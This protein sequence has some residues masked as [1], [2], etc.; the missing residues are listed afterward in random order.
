MARA[1]GCSVMERFIQVMHGWSRRRQTIILFQ[2]W[3]GVFPTGELELGRWIETDWFKPEISTPHVVHSDLNQGRSKL[4]A[5]MAARPC[6][7]FS[8]S[9]IVTVTRLVP[10]AS[11]TRVGVPF[12]F[13]VPS[14]TVFRQP[15]VNLLRTEN[16]ELSR[17]DRSPV[18]KG[19]W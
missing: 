8:R 16:G 18:V 6:S 15:S 9:L 4:F 5:G 10:T 12:L 2:A 17:Q 14:W 11:C 3:L 13:F 19:L 7:S 1:G